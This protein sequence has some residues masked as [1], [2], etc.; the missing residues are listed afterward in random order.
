MATGKPAVVTN[1]SGI[2]QIIDDGET[3]VLLPK[4]NLE[5]LA[6]AIVPLLNDDAKRA[7]MGL[8]ARKRA[9]SKLSWQIVVRNTKDLYDK[10]P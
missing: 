9:D 2:P 3:G 8:K 6:H 4:R 10:I 7:R 1:V 5:E